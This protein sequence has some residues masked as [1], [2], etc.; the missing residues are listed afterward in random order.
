MGRGRFITIEGIEGSGKST[1]A[2]RLAEALRGAGIPVRVTREPGG[3]V[4]A[5]AV[6]ELIVSRTGC[7]WSPTSEALLHY[8]ARREHLDK[9]VVPALDVGKWIVCDRFADS[10]M[11]YQGYGQELGREVVERLHDLVVG[12]LTPDLTVVL[13]LPVD[14]GLDRARRRSPD[15]DRYERMDMAFHGRVRDAF[16]DIARREPD[17]CVVIDADREPGLIAQDVRAAVASRTGAS[18]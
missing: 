6:R 2:A 10:T 4:G 12:E 17:R 16:L 13:D 5:E 9:T 8:A 15:G 14:R 7:D 18:L 1:Q 3:A 11:A